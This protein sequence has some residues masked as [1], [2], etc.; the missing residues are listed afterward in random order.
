MSIGLHPSILKPTFNYDRDY[1]NQDFYSTVPGGEALDRITALLLYKNFE[2]RRLFGH[3]IA[4][5][6]LR[7]I[8][9]Q[10][11]HFFNLY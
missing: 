7:T 1:I 5:Q 9:F 6:Q 10:A 4:T 8:H 11:V 2:A 3:C